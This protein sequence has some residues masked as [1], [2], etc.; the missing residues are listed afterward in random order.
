MKNAYKV[1]N[2]EESQ[3]GLIQPQISFL[4]NY[5]NPNVTLPFLK[6]INPDNQGLP[7]MEMPDK[8]TLIQRVTDDLCNIAEDSLKKEGELVASLV[9][10]TLTSKIIAN[11][12]TKEVETQMSIEDLMSKLYAN[13]E[14]RSKSK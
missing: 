10:D 14:T 4:L 7:E 6:F 3:L 1:T 8:N 5:G 11:I 12:E 2:I 9:K 13:D